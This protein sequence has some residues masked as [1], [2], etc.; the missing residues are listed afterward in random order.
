[1]NKTITIAMLLTALTAAGCK[2]KGGGG[3]AAKG[4]ELPDSV[5]E[6]TPAGADAALQ[7]AW[8]ARMTLASNMGGSHSMAGD[9]IALDIKAE[10]ATAFDGKLEKQLSWVVESPCTINGPPQSHTMLRAMNVSCT[11]MPFEL[12]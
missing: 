10:T 5:M 9:P 8:K 3:S 11:P 2:K 1:M 12:P 4:R 6:W 7:G